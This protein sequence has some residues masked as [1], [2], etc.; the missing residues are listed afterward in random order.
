MKNVI[1]LAS[2]T[3][4]LFPAFSCHKKIM[5]F[6]PD[7]IVVVIEENHGYNDII[8]SPYAPYI[9]QLAKGSALFTDAHGV[10][11]PS[12]PNYLAIFSGSTQG[13]PDD[14]CLKNV[15][16]FTTPNLG[17][18]LISKGYTF[19]GYAQSMPEAGYL[20]CDSLMDS[21]TGGPVYARKHVPWVDWQGMGTNNI[22]YTL[23]QPMTAFPTDFTKL[24]T[25][26]FV[27]PD[28]DHDM[29]NI[30][31]P[32][33]SAA[34]KRGDDWLKDNLG[35]YADWAKTH[36]SLLIV[37]Y[38]EDKFTTQNQ[39]PTFIWGANVRPGKYSERINHYNVLRTIQDFYDLPV[40]DT[41]H[42]TPITNVWEKKS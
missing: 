26:A 27:I 39:I 29:H 37:T 41:T 1:T 40:T 8:G 7:H 2:L 17:A 33:D 23:S 42:A 21:I 18:A 25:V 34:I 15:T 24:P 22:P 35:A 12:Q 36:H 11:H 28:E 20:E 9:N 3:L 38:D 16:P 14:R 4:C 30:G 31:T 13:I 6:Q 32:G 5:G 10:T 19:T